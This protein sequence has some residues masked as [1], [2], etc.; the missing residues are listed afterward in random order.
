MITLI[1]RGIVL[2]V[3]IF[4]AMELF[5][6]DKPSLKLNACMVIVPLVLRFLMIK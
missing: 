2:M 1:Y 3:L 5:K 4:T 6:E